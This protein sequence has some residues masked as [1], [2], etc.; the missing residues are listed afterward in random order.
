MLQEIVKQ[1]VYWCFKAYSPEA[2]AHDVP[3]GTIFTMAMPGEEIQRL[4]VCVAAENINHLDVCS[5][6][7]E[8]QAEPFHGNL[9]DLDFGVAEHRARE[10]ERVLMSLAQEA[11][12]HE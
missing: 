11:R 2:L 9:T 8:F 4:M 1:K 3:I 5:I 10:G 6:D 12:K 7:D